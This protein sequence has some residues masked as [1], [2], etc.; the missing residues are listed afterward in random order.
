ME[1]VEVRKQLIGTGSLPLRCGL[2]RPSSSHE[3]GC[4]SALSPEPAHQPIGQLL[5]INSVHASIPIYTQESM[6][7]INLMKLLSFI[8]SFSRILMFA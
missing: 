5:K 3:A 2:H 4:V 7:D 8:Q 6:C 1:Y